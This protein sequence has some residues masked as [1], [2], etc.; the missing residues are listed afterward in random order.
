MLNL[1][2]T[3]RLACAT[4][5]VLS[6]PFSGTFCQGANG[7]KSSPSDAVRFFSGRW[8]LTLKLFPGTPYSSCRGCQ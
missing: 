3:Y 2:G 8:D 1:H 7:D 5:L 6:F 4:F